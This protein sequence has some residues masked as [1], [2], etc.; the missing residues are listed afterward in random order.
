[1]EKVL[2]IYE[3]PYNPLRPVICFDERPCQLLGDV[4]MP[5][6]MKPGRVER[7]DYHYERNGTCVV[8]MAVEPLAGHRIVK[9]TKRKT[10]ED[11]AEFMKELASYY[12]DADKIVLVQDNL[13]THNPSSFY[14][15]FDAPE[16]FALSERF[17]MVYTPKKA[18]WLN[19]A[20][21]ELSVL[22]KQ[23]LDRRIA[24]TSILNQEVRTWS[25]RRNQLQ[26]KI[27]WQFTKNNAREKLSRHYDI[28]NN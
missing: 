20:E 21:I 18:S 19:M 23:C 26:T 28:I 13:N 27:T 14:E 22:S 5:I 3:Q 2:D 12:S 10:K 7:Q 24:K 15:L 11:Y 25:K 8:L 1:M 16:A 9:V 17:E 6:P 4:L